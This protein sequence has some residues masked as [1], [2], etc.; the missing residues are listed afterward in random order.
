[1]S[2]SKKIFSIK[3]DQYPVILN[4]RRDLSL[5]RSDDNLEMEPDINNELDDDDVWDFDE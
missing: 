3:N 2:I 1:M 4:T 5:F